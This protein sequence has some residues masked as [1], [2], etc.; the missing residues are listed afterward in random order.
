[1]LELVRCEAVR[2]VTPSER[3][4]YFRPSSSSCEPTLRCARFPS[5]C[6]TN[7]QSPYMTAAPR[8]RAPR[9]SESHLFLSVASLQHA[10]ISFTLSPR[11]PPSHARVTPPKSH[12]CGVVCH[13]DSRL[14]SLEFIC[15]HL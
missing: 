10:G 14:I 2:K 8:L 3:A 12:V 6:Q 7:S 9:L 1:M 4:W 15:L 13:R 5:L 11:I